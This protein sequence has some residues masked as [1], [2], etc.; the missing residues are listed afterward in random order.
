MAKFMIAHLDSGPA[1][2]A[3]IL[4]ERALRFMQRQHATMHPRLPGYALGF[5]E[6]YVGRLRVIE[7]GGNMAGFSSQMVLIPEHNAGFFY[8]GHREGSSFRDEVKEAVLRRYYPSARQR[9]PRPQPRAEFRKRVSDFTGRYIPMTG[10]SSCKPRRAPYVMTV[11][12]SSDSSAISFAG[13]NWVEVAPDL[14]AQ[15]A[16]TG[17]IAFRRDTAGKVSEIFAGGFWSFERV[18]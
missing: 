18:P 13:S 14:F 2:G 10:C 12:A 17:Y 5:Y 11:A 16:G 9:I 15:H 6:D 7:H 8:V 3:R 4:S 1:G